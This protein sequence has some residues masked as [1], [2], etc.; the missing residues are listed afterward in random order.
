MDIS[1]LVTDARLRAG[2]S[3]RELA[4]R[5]GTSQSAVARIESGAVRP[6]FDTAR[7][8]VAACGFDLRVTLAPASAPRPDRVVEAYK[9]DVDR[10]LLRENLSKSVERRLGDM[11]AF[12]KSAE[13]LRRGVTAAGRGARH[14]SS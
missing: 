12:R 14:R 7:R 11:E 10:T 2:L 9:R 8:L 13:Q 1:T 4:T 3:Q 6:S 5:A